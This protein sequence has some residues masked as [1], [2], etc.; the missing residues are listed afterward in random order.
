MKG[1]S[2]AIL[3]SVCMIFSVAGCGNT[4]EKDGGNV[5]PNNTQESG[6]GGQAGS[7]G[8]DAA[9]ETPAEAVELKGWGAWTFD[10]QSGVT[11]YNEQLLW[12]QVKE[13]LNISVE[14]TTVAAADKVTLFSLAMSDD[15]NIPDFITDMSPL[16]YEE[17]GRLGA[18]IPLN[19]YIT[20]EKMPNLCA[21]LEEYPDARA[22]ITSADGNIYFFPR[23]MEA[24]TR[25]WSGLFIRK[26]FLDQVELDIPKTTE[27]F[28]EA[29]A[30]IKAGVDTVD[31]PLGVN[32]G[33]LKAMLSFWNIGARGTGTSTTDDAYIKDGKIAYGPAEDAYR[34]ALIYF[35]RMYEEGLLNPDW[36]SLEAA[37]IRTNILN[38]STAVAEG[39][40]SGILSTYN[41]LLTED[42]QGEALTYVDPLEGPEGPG[43][44]QGHHTVLD[45]GCGSAISASCSNVDAVIR[46]VDYL[47][48]GEGRELVYWG[49]EGETFTK[50][51]D[52]YEFTEKVATSSLGVLNYLNSY[53]GNTSMYPTAMLTDFYHATLS[54]LAKEGNKSI[55]AIG[56]ANDIRMPAL[57]YSEEEIAEVNTISVDLNNYVDEN[58][59][60]FVNG[61]TDIHDDGAWQAYLDG[62]SGL[63]LDEILSYHQT[64]YERWLSNL[65]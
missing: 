48:G 63:R 3:L 56:E 28:Y 55:T 44:R 52:S 22:S 20:P 61:V 13:R 59:A 58:F 32:M 38:K 35:N 12:Q 16:V 60:N 36:N 43:T 21:L 25:Y 45:V 40:F 57:R 49:V 26:D 2:L 8:E 51:G 11:S 10:E 14:W 17:Y 30:A 23:I 7:A 9:E 31:F 50:N 39:S 54:D 19:D 64:A 46:M 34:D 5:V 6:S 37:D 47:Y 15:A 27:E 24:S 62:F 1:K 4:G 29:M 65:E 41:S 33:S 18:L 53:S 42:G